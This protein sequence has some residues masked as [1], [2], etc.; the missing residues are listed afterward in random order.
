MYAAV[1]FIPTVMPLLRAQIDVIAVDFISQHY[2]GASSSNTSTA[3]HHRPGYTL[4]KYGRSQQVFGT[5]EATRASL[6][7]VLF[8]AEPLRHSPIQYAHTYCSSPAPCDHLLVSVS[9][10]HLR[11]GHATRS[12]RSRADDTADRR[13]RV[14]S[15]SAC[16]P[17]H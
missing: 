1:R 13:R 17:A 8:R 9:H 16:A 15:W 4:A 5:F 6:G 10:V 7:A 12:W 14:G 3:A 11:V 2:F